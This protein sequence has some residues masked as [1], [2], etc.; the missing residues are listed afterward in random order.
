MSDPSPAAA[1]FGGDEDPNAEPMDLQ[2]FSAEEARAALPDFADLIDLWLARR[3]SAAVPDWSAVDFADFRG[4]HDSIVLGVFESDEP[5]PTLRLAGQTYIDVTQQ[6]PTGRR[7][8]ELAPR[9]FDLYFREH[10]RQ[11]RD[12][13]LIGL[14]S[15]RQ[16][17]KGRSHVMLRILEL[18]FRDGGAEVRRT[19][20]VLSKTTRKD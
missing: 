18:P 17:L 8:S 12:H 2:C 13:G 15:G 4:W 19:V 11:I 7:M 1:I 6:N 3:G 14:A 5:D 9:M 20:H 10:F 16:P